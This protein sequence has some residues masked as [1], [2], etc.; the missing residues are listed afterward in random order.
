MK[1]LKTTLLTTVAALAIA[2]PAIAQDTSVDADASVKTE[3][4]QAADSVE[5]TMD[6]AGDAAAEAVDETADATEEAAEETGDAVTDTAD[7]AGDAM[8]NTAEEATDMATD[9]DSSMS[10]DA[11]VTADA[12]PMT[13]DT[14]VGT[15]VAASSGE[16]IGEIDR[17][18]DINGETMAVVGVGGFLGIGE[19]D[20]AL[21]VS[22]LMY[23]GN[24]IVAMGYTRE[25]LKS[26][27]EYNAELATDI[28]GDAV[29]EL[30]DS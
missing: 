24:T 6:Q 14:V 5:N 4:G 16:S 22:E 21:P 25:Q 30:G 29:V 11:E 13:V 10:A 3:M 12:G 1:P 15:N 2:A 23:D 26:M 18:V 28:E 27:A 20:V 9:T 19:H 7:A 8:E 17:I